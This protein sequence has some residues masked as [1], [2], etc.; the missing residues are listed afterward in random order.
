L[1]QE[2]LNPIS[3]ITKARRAGGVA[4]A[5]EHLPNKHKALSANPSINKKRKSP[6]ELNI[7]SL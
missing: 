2:G 4:Q 5:V 1:V 3:K 6:N 7:I